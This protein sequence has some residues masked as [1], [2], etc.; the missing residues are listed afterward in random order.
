M[1]CQRCGAGIQFK[2]VR[3]WIE[4][5]YNSV[6]VCIHRYRPILYCNQKKNSSETLYAYVKYA[7]HN[8]NKLMIHA[9]NIPVA[10]V[11]SKFQPSNVISNEMFVDKTMLTVRQ[12]AFLIRI[13]S[14]KVRCIEQIFSNNAHWL[15]HVHNYEL[16]GGNMTFSRLHKVNMCAWLFQTTML[17]HFET[18]LSCLCCP[19]LFKLHPY[20]TQ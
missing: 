4:L 2:Y 20:Y 9:T 8:T 12:F 11:S 17:L 5:W 18:T 3:I 7:V 6:R 10:D 16:K 15:I 13:P 19:F 1:Y 14:R